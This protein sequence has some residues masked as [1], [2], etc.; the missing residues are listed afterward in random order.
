[1]FNK[2]DRHE[3]PSLPLT[4]S[5][6]SDTQYSMK[7]KRFMAALEDDFRETIIRQVI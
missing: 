6:E 7:R 4:M 5:S 1:M 2:T 3:E